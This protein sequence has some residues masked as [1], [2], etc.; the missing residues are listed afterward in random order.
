MASYIGQI[1]FKNIYDYFYGK[2][3]REKLDYILEPFQAITQLALLSFCPVGS[4][5]TIN[6]NILTIQQPGISQG[7]IRYFND[8]NKEDLYYLM[9]VFRRFFEY[10]K[11]MTDNEM[12]KLYNLLIKLSIKGIEKLTETYTN[13]NKI[14]VLHTLQMYKVVLTNQDFF[15]NN[16]VNSDTNI[17]QI[18]IKITQIYKKEEYNVILNL[19]LL[20]EKN[21]ESYFNY[22]DGINTIM[23]N[24]N[25]KIKQWID[26][27]IL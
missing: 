19:L 6:D 2:K 12:E 8:D 23:D 11:F 17:D 26:K 1:G 16:D 14:N 22:I 10:Y 21:N 13:T 24:T 7:I 5:L 18:F 3:Q 15:N 9:N 4:K 27:N 20:L 25:K